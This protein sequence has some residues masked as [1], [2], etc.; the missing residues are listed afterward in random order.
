MVDAANVPRFVENDAWANTIPMLQNGWRPTG[1]QVNPATDE[2]L[3]NW[4][5]RELT[6]RT[7]YLRARIDQLA[8]KA[9]TLVTVGAGGSYATINAALSGLSERRPGYTPGGFSTEVRLLAGF[10]MAEQVLVRGVNLGWINITSVAA[11]VLIDRAYLVTEFQGVYPAFG[12]ADGGTLPVIGALF[13]MTGTGAAANRIGV[14]GDTGGVISINA[15]AG[16]KN[17]GADGLRLQTAAAV[18]ANGAIFSGAGGAAASLAG[19]TR[20]T[21]QSADL[22]NAQYGITAGNGAMVHASL[23]NCSGASIQGIT[24]SSGAIINAYGANARKGASD[25]SSDFLVASGGIITA[26]TGTGGTSTAANTVTANGII[27]K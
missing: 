22:R 1:G 19:G 17:A 18:A 25:S 16:V 4:P 11:E 10:T 9:G 8:L 6:N 3:L 7:R 24:A 23:A 5:L 13:S 20:A 21:L 2:G 12:V 27:F 26:T 14:F 15:G